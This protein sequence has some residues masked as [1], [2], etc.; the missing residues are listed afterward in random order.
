LVDLRKLIDFDVCWPG[1]GVILIDRYPD[2][3]KMRK[4]A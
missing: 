1:N 4:F 3:R 2:G